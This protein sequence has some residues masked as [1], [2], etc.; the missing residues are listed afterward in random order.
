MNRLIVGLKQAGL[1]LTPQ[2]V[3]ICQVL[4]ESKD[5]PTAM[6]I[7]HQLLPQFPTLS[8]ATV[9]KTLHVLNRWTGACAGDAATARSISTP[10]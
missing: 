5:H 7:Y 1:R 6:M 8:L 3:A 9:Y 10:T 4:A 2:R